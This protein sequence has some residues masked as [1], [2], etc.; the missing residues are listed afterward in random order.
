MAETTRGARAASASTIVVI[1]ALDTKGAEVAFLKDQ[2]EARGHRAL[3]IDSGVLGE[4]AF[5]AE[6]RD[7]YVGN[8]AAQRICRSQHRRRVPG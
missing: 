6:T 2:I 4:P 1:G 7:L 3:V 5:G 8:L